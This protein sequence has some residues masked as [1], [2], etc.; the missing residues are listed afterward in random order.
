MARKLSSI[1]Q[2][3]TELAGQGKVDG[4][5]KNAGNAGKLAGLLED[6]RDAIMEY[7]VRMLLSCLLLRCLT[8][9]LDLIATRYLRQVL[10]AHRESSTY[11]S[12]LVLSGWWIERK[13]FRPSQQDASR[14]WSR[15][16]L[17]E[18]A[19][20]SEGNKEGCPGSNRILAG[21]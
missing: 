10:S 7:Q 11:S 9:E 5:L 3:L 21:G 18:Q 2:D 16:P 15:I 20:M 1:D 19:G 6:V 14:R 4:F 13:G 8:F 12:L 17:W